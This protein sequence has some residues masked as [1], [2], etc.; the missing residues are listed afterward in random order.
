[1]SSKKPYLLGAHIST[2]GGFYKAIERGSSI[3]CTAIQIFTKS[4]RQWHAKTITPSAAEAFKDAQKKSHIKYVIAHA[5]YLINLGSNNKDVQEKSISALKTE[6]ER[7]DEL[8]IPYLVL[9]PGS[10]SKAEKAVC[11]EVVA[12]NLNKVLEMTSGNTMLLL[13]T[14]AGQ[15][16]SIGSQLEDIAYIRKHSQFKKRIGVC[17]DTCH[18]FVAGYD[19]TTPQKY[20]AV[21]NKFD[22]V[23]GLKHLKA[24]HLNDSKKEL[25]SRVDRH[26]CIGKGFIPIEAFKM[27]CNDPRFFDVPI[28][29]ETPNETLEG[30]WKDM[31]VIKSLLSKETKEEVM[32]GIPDNL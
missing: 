31:K 12:D 2:E 26:A 13:E 21:W 19:Y 22:D 10:N 32:V 8:E 4:N 6:L 15:G 29:L 9:H 28:I 25:G 18:A 7:C 11:L 14:M 24:I 27:L 30:Y 17:F 5:A 1:M 20:E 23:I 16:G 3:G